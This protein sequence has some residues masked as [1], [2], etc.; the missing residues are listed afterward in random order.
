MDTTVAK[1]MQVLETLA[2]AKGPLRLSALAEQLGLQKSNVH[3]LLATLG[4]LGY[5]T[6]EADTSR[7]GATLKLWELGSAVLAEHPAKRIAAPFMLELHR[8]TALTVSLCV[9][10]GDDVLY[11]HKILA[12]NPMRLTTQPGSRSPAPLTAS[13]KALLAHHPDARSIVASV[14]RN[15]PRAKELKS[16]AF[17]REL[18][19][20]RQRGHAV[21]DGGWTPGIVSI[22]AAI[23]GRDGHAAASLSLSGAAS[24]MTPDVIGRAT[25][26]LM[27]TCTRIAETVGSV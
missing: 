26:A 25:E 18:E 11:L 10:D 1:A 20:V 13:G 3:R 6:Q 21:S 27:S 17:L 16:A 19:T 2:R 22:A 15:E 23:M 5:V 8:E 14:I 7:Y 24:Q 9:L 12:P 4:E